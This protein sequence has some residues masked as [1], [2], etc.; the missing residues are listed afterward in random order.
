MENNKLIA[1]FM[2]YSQ[3][4]PYYPNTTYWYK[5]GEAPLTILSFDTDWNWLM[6]VVEKI[7]ELGFV[8]ELSGNGEHNFLTISQP[9]KH[10]DEHIVSMRRTDIPPNNKKITTYLGVVQFITWYNE[11]KQK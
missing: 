1:N 11:T 2:G 6:A 10:C 5:E 9:M 3:P 7:E 4:H 8:T